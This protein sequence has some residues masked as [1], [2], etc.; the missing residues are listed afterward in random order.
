MLHVITIAYRFE[1][2]DKIYES[3]SKYE[4]VVWHVSKSSRREAFTHDFSL[5]P[6]VRLYEVDCAD[7]QTYEKRNAALS[8]IKDGYFCFVDDDTLFHENMHREYL[9]CKNKNFVGMVVGEQVS[10]SGNKRLEASEPIMSKID[11]GNALA[12]HSCLS[13]VAWPEKK[14]PGN[15]RDFMFWDAVCRFYGGQCQLVHEPVS[16]YNKLRY[17]LIWGAMCSVSEGVFAFRQYQ[18]VDPK[19][20]LRIR[21]YD[22]DTEELVIDDTTDS[23]SQ[24]AWHYSKDGISWHIWAEKESAKDSR[25][26]KEGYINYVPVGHAGDWVKY[27]ANSFNP[28]ANP[29]IMLTYWT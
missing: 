4:D 8:V 20:N 7:E 28:V 15:E 9:K 5:D 2:L 11:T 13:A 3:L 12:H 23:S 24:G 10:W 29:K 22:K 18:P 25:E 16:H 14:T 27:T 1:Q 21:I 26:G 19:T 6:R 17:F